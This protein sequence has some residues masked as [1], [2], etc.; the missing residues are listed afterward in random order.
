[1]KKIVIIAKKELR[2]YF[3]SLI[4]YIMLILF[5]GFTGF[6]TWL[7]GADVF[8]SQ[9]AS[10][11]SFFNI[12]Y[13]T[14]FFFIPA[15]TMR[16]FAEENR[17]GTLEFLLTKPISD[18]QIVLGKFWATFILIALALLLT[19]S[20]G[21]TVAFLGN[22]DTGA[23]I[24]GYLGLLFMSAAYISIGLLASS[25]SNN[26]IVA[27]LIALFISIFFHIIFNVLAN[28]LGG[29]LGMIFDYLSLSSHYDS[30]SRGV[31]DLKDILYFISIVFVGLI[32]TEAVLARKRA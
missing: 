4:A 16:M 9:Q 8:Y 24:S 27:L 10:L 26:Q 7:Y 23:T 21:I 22:I 13:W 12:S 20:F 3:D 19:L 30:I 6:F 28:S 25:I 11:D 5:L 32:G 2:S 15:L 14:L 17:L 18:W 31:I 1:M 29:T